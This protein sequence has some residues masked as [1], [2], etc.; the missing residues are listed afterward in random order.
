MAESDR[1]DTLAA[2]PTVA[3]IATSKVVTRVFEEVLEAIH[4]GTLLPGERI[5]DTAL[6]AKYGVS[7]TPVREALQ[8]LREI[9]VVEASANRFTRV[10]VVSPRTTAE[11]LVVWSALFG[12]LLD[13][14]IPGAGPDVLAEMSKD[15]ADF[16]A[17]AVGPDMQALAT[18][19]FSFFSRLTLRTEN[20]LL[21]RA[22]TSVV[23]LV[24]LGGLHLP[25]DIDYQ[26]LYD[27][28]STLLDAV[29]T[30][31]VA[32]AHQAIAAIKGIRIPLEPDRS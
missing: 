32:L 8:R 7:R 23:H 20:E 12:A 4:Q 5:N 24:R 1:E 28:Q 25:E 18:H 10:A 16:K 26:A 13:E 6:A 2:T 17:A 19:N 30:R 11:A 27:A 21:R 15:H 14:T 9:G 22:I 3:G 31:D 29:R